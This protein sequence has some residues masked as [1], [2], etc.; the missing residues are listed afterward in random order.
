[1]KELN[2]IYLH[3]HAENEISKNVF[4][5]NNFTIIKREDQQKKDM[6]QSEISDDNYGVQRSNYIEDQQMNDVSI[7]TNPLTN[8]YIMTKYI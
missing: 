6:K 3:T 4:L 2:I 1:M 7:Y 8:I 5:K